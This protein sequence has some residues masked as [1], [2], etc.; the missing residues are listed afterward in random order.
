M[1]NYILL[2]LVAMLLLTFNFGLLTVQA[3]T[4]EQFKYQAVLRN[5]DGTVMA[6]EDVTVDISILQ[7][8]TTG[9]SVFDESHSVTTTAQGLINLNIGSIEDLS[10]I[11]WG[12]ILIL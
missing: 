9:T 4:P 12:A 7:G 5:A 6:N 8:S 1:K 11:D 3:Q 2:K 10:V